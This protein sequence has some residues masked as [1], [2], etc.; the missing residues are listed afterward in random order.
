ME[1][2]TSIVVSERTF[3]RVGILVTAVG[4]ARWYP[5]RDINITE[6]RANEGL[7]PVPIDPPA[8]SRVTEKSGDEPD[9]T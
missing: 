5:A 3:N 8:S 1:I 7:I 4:V 2:N 9:T 6:I